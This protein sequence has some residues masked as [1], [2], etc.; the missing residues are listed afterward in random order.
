MLRALGLGQGKD[1]VAEV[2]QIVTDDVLAIMRKADNPKR[3]PGGY[4][5]LYTAR[6]LG[7]RLDIDPDQIRRRT[8][9]AKKRRSKYTP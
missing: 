3:N 2:R 4:F 5:G 7:G 1:V 8:N 9:R 6:E